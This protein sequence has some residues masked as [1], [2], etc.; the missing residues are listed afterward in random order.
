VH[1]VYCVAFWFTRGAD[2]FKGVLLETMVDLNL[3]QPK[4]GSECCLNLLL[5]PSLNATYTCL[6]ATLV[7]VYEGFF[8]TAGISVFALAV[9]FCFVGRLY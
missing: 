8:E 2:S 5:V 9:S 6:Q 1:S 4:K 3:G 7:R